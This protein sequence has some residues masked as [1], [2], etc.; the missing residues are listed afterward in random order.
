M[1][2]QGGR[3][4]GFQVWVNLP[5]RL[6]M[7]RPRY[8]EISAAS[9]PEARSQDGKARVRV[10]AGEALGAH[11]VID[12]NTPIVFQDWRIDPGADVAIPIPTDHQ[13]LVYAFEGVVDVGDEAKTI[14]EGQLA[15][16]GMGDKVRLR[17][18]GKATRS[19]RLLL[20]AGVPIVEPV[21]HYGPF[22]MNTQQELV[23]AMRDY[24]SGRMGEITRT[25]QFD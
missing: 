20:L 10:I 4:H 23:Q 11:A 8:Q 5:A 18:P 7:T 17:G 14:R 3:V 15:L 12:T 6:K 13:A 16:L 25:A 19:G 24:Q 2:E 21:A 1:R 9:I 22:V